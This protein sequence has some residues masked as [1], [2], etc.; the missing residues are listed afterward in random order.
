MSKVGNNIKT[1]KG[2]W[3]FA[4]PIVVKNFDDHVLKSVPLYKEGHEIII[5]LSDFF[6]KEN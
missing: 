1:N 5:D 2:K 6:L 4:K 3:T